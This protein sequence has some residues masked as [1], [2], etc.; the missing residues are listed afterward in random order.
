MKFFIEIFLSKLRNEKK[1]TPEPGEQGMINGKEPGEAIV[2]L[3]KL[4]RDKAA[5]SHL[6]EKY[7]NMCFLDKDPEDDG[8]DTSDESV[9]EHR[10]IQNVVWGRRLGH[11]VDTVIISTNDDPPDQV[12]AQTY[13]INAALLSMI[14]DSPHNTRRIKSQIN[15]NL[16]V[17]SD[18]DSSESDAP[19]G[20]IA[21][22]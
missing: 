14:R 9:W 7:Y 22:I 21:S 12:T 18:P 15:V 10:V 20:H 3:T 13:Q 17:D 8:G 19:A 16:T 11:V 6:F 2:N 1:Y 4:R 5:R